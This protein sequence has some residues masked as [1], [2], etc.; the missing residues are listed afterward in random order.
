MLD[1]FWQSYLLLLKGSSE[2]R[3]RASSSM[4]NKPP[5]YSVITSRTSHK[6]ALISGR[7]QGTWPWSVPRCQRREFE[8]LWVPRGED[9]VHGEGVHWVGVVVPDE[10]GHVAQIIQKQYKKWPWSAPWWP[11]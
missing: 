8:G 1:W 3:Q 6:L 5:Q 7:G 4:P 9:G 10:V 11:I 2:E